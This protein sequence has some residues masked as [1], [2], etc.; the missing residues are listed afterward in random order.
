MCAV[1]IIAGGKSSRLGIDK[2]FVE[3]GGLTLLENILRKAAENFSEIFLCVEE[4]LPQ[5]KILAEKYGAKISVDEVQGVGPIAALATTLKKISTEKALAVSVDMPFFDF[6]IL[7]PLMNFDEKIIVPIV[8]GRA[9]PLAAIYHKL[10][11]KFFSDELSAG[12]RKLIDAIKK[13]PHQFIQIETE[14]FFNVNTPADLKLARGRAENL[15]RKIPVISIVAPTSDTGKTTFIE[16][17]LRRLTNLKTGVVK[18]SHHKILA[19]KISADSHRFL[20]AGAKKV[21]VGEKFFEELERMDADLIL[22]ESRTHGIFPAISLWRGSG[23]VIADENVVA[24]FSS[25][26]Q[27][28]D[29]IFQFDINDID[30]ALKI[31]N[32]LKHES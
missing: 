21:Y 13:V 3:V 1:M 6:E 16:K 26:P 14:K 12:R 4:I 2:R 9:Q 32:F 28:S 29:E 25:K 5:I 7:K 31:C 8:S 24:I 20:K 18:S 23:E 30:A 22:T 19:D 17:I 15:S 10:T 27:T 11:A